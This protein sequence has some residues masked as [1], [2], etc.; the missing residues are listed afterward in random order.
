M[1]K[2]HEP[3][4]YE[5]AKYYDLINEKYVPY[6]KQFSFIEGAFRKYQKKVHSILDLAC[7][8][9]IHSLYFARKGYRVVGIDLSSEM[10]SIARQKARIERVEIDFLEGDIRDLH[11]NREFDAAIC[12]NQSVMSCVTY[13]DISN[14]FIGVKNALKDAGIF[15]VD[16]LSEYRIGEYTSK[17]SVDSGDVKIECIREERYD[18]MRQVMIDRTTYFVSESG[19]IKRFEG[20]GE[21]RVFYPQEMLFYLKSMGN[22]KTLGLHECWSLE[23]KPIGPYLVAV[24]ER[25]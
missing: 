23:Q 21:G 19:V 11:F 6:E 12:V 4:Y 5:L 8:T 15:V 20:Y 14:F 2:I 7:G 16:F 9:G 1:T 25:T 3:E 22:F 18:P 24:A 13:T 17:E 10:L